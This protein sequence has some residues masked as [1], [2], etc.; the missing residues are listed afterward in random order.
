[1]RIKPENIPAEL[2]EIDRWVVWKYEEREGKWTKVPY[3]AQTGGAT[4]TSEK[5]R[6]SWSSF[7]AAGGRFE[8]G[9]WDGIGF[10]FAADDDIV[11]IDLDS[12]RDP[13]TG[14][15]SVWAALIV[16]GLWSY[17][18]VTPSGTGVHILL[19]GKLPPGERR[20]GGVEMYEEG[21]YFTVTG[22]RLE[23]LPESLRERSR[24]LTELHGRIFS[25]RRGAEGAPRNGTDP[26]GVSEDVILGKLFANPKYSALWHGDVSGYPSPSEADLAL[27]GYIAFLAGPD[28]S[29]I[30]RLFQQSQLMREK[31]TSASH[32]RAG[33]TYGADTIRAAVEGKT[34]FYDWN[35]PASNQDPFVA[36]V[37]LVADYARIREPSRPPTELE[38]E[39]LYGLP[40]DVVKAIL[41]H[42][43]SHA[44]AIL[45]N[46]LIG[47][48]CLVGRRPHV[49]RDGARHGANEFACLVGLTSTGRKGTATRR[50]DE[51]FQSLFAAPEYPD[52]DSSDKSDKSR[53]HTHETVSSW[54]DLVIGGLG[55]GE[56]LIS[57]LAEENEQGELEP[58]RLVFEEEFSRCLKIMAREHST[59]SEMLRQAWDGSRMENRVKG[60]V[61]RAPPSHVAIM[62]HITEI[63]MRLRLGEAELF[64]GFANRFLWVCVD[65]SKYLPFGGGRAALGPVVSALQRA[66]AHARTLD[67]LEFDAEASRMW[68]EGGLY[69]A[70]DDRPPGLL[71]AVTAR[72][73]SHVTRLALQWAVFDCR[74]E[75]G[76]GH[77]MAALAFW[78]FCEKSCAYLFGTSLGDE[79]ADTILELAQESYPAALT[80]TEIRDRF[81]R[82][83][84]P[85]RI[86]AA[87]RLLEERGYLEHAQAETG[88]RPV[89]HWRFS[90]RVVRDQSDI[91]DKSHRDKSDKSPLQLARALIEEQEGR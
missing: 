14:A 81:R 5:W 50:V 82:H 40:G 36:N 13:E 38:P 80:R 74:R 23:M 67:T 31:W 1:V 47:A 53:F 54:S 78:D 61:L 48:G 58:R 89:E 70:L 16:D 85:G 52:L 27:C 8:E 77:L 19:H 60:K 28:F 17:T 25:K 59:L 20:K 6:P 11:G 87:L 26:A 79:Y 34:Q 63:E 43:E 75:I 4:G 18:E 15:L 3:S 32:G 2:R 10:V 83:A 35:R 90:P 29:L 88:G 56:A 69:R 44:A 55:S 45:A 65:R 57:S 68:E 51:V 7:A 24:A 37:A 30:D 72:A 64:N 12:C 21:R 66:I 33:S 73:S 9:G 84:A 22:E 62:G 86:P 42:T 91:S 76:V 46:F 49:Y 39:A 41:P 71:G